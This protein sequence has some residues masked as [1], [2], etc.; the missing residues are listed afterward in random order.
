MKT[1]KKRAGKAVALRAQPERAA[2]G[3]ALPELVL[4]EALKGYKV[5]RAVSMRLRKFATDETIYIK[6]VSP[7]TKAPPSSRARLNEEGARMAP[8]YICEIVDLAAGTGEIM[9]LVA[10]AVLRGELERTYP[11]KGEQDEEGNWE[12]PAD[13]YVGRS[14]A[15]QSFP[16]NDALKQR[17]RTFRIAEL[18]E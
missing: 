14:F 6:I 2:I 5:K 9:H 3:A 4:P 18:E 7:F 15:I 8:P 11:G 12:P 10:P 17:Y 13:G 16:R 1:T